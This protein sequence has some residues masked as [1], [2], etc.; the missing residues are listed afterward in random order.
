MIEEE[1]VPP[2]PC[3]IRATRIATDACAGT[4]R[5]VIT[6]Q[7]QLR[8]ARLRVVDASVISTTFTSLP[9]AEDTGGE[10]PNIGPEDVLRPLIV[11]DSVVRLLITLGALSAR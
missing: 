5:Q 1:C 2:R 4:P 8:W 7:A 10:N 3:L 9:R 6:P 11:G